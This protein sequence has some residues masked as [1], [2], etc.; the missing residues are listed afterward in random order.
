MSILNERL[1]VLFAVELI[2]EMLPVVFQPKVGT[3]SRLFASAFLHD[4]DSEVLEA[5][6]CL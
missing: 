3:R 2:N 4:E 5:V 1:F 6:V